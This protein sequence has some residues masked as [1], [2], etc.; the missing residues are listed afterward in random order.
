MLLNIKKHIPV[1]VKRLI[2]KILFAGNNFYCNCCNSNVRS[3]MS[4]GSNHEAIIRYKI[5]GAGYHKNDMCPVCHSGYRQRLIKAY[6]DYSGLLNSVKDIMHFA[7]EESLYH[8]LNNKRYNYTTADI[9]PDKYAYYSKP[10][11]AD[12]C[13]LDFDDNSFDL[14]LVNHILEHIIDDLKAMK[15][16]YRVLKPGGIAIV[17]VPISPILENTYEDFSICSPE[18]R[19]QHFGQIDHVRIYG[20]DYAKK[21]SEAGFKVNTTKPS[22][23]NSLNKFNKLMLDNREKL[24]IASK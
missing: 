11:Y 13:S 21:L 10:V 3:F 20:M 7:P 17:Q 9:N 23:M 15:E 4:G 22:E 12:L 16:I 1:G 14:V 19:L 18:D 24:F 6:F 5:I 2:R 8:L